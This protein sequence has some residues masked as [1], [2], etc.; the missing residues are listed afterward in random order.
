MTL[1][2]YQGDGSVRERVEIPDFQRN[3]MFLDE[4]G[5]FLRCFERHETPV[6]SLRDGAQSLKTAL[7]ARESLRTGKV[8]E[9]T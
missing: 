3:Q 4:M 2:V 5:A 9:V 6:V 7:A 1:V 8:V